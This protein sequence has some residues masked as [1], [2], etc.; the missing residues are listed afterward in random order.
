LV[1]YGGFYLQ[2]YLDSPQN[3]NILIQRYLL[4]ESPLHGNN[5]PKLWI[6]TVYNM[7]AHDWKHGQRNTK[8]L[9]QPFL[10]MTIKTIVDHC[11]KDFNVCL[12]DDSVFAKLLPDWSYGGDISQA[13]DQT[14][15]IRFLGL[16]KIIH[17]YG[18][19]VVPNS[20]VCFRS[21]LPIV[22][23]E[24]ANAFCFTNRH[25]KPD[26][27]VFGGKKQHP[28][29]QQC[30]EIQEQTL[31]RLT[32]PFCKS[33]LMQ[34]MV[35][36]SDLRV[37]EGAL[38]GVRTKRHEPILID[39]L[40]GEKPLEFVDPVYGILISED[41]LLSRT[42]Y[43]WFAVLSKEEIADSRVQLAQYLIQ[44]LNTFDPKEQEEDGELRTVGTI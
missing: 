39:D 11:S 35:N 22:S 4:N 30:I 32:S 1:S 26:F 27:T 24:E 25:G 19:T 34:H 20:F 3:E 8:E 16:L 44:A 28:G 29:I 41:E 18:G 31:Q 40:M 43:S 12:I 38:L 17:M 14:S 9:H 33:A 7:N 37:K 6:H 10:H 5:K 23:G 2:R 36:V 13:G 21:L 15:N 42:K